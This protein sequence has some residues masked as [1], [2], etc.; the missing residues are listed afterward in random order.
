MSSPYRIKPCPYCEQ[1][2]RFNAWE[3]TWRCRGCNNQIWVEWDGPSD[4]FEIK[5]RK[6]EERPAPA[7]DG[8][9]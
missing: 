4:D 8:D 7:H 3:E 1:P 9:G 6:L 2:V 5:L